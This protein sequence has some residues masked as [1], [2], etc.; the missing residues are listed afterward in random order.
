M[1][2]EFPEQVK[3][4]EDYIGSFS[5]K[6]RNRARKILKSLEHVSLRV[7]STEEVEKEERLYALYEEVYMHAKFKLL[8]LPSNYFTECKRIFKD[9]FIV[10]GFYK[11]NRLIAFGSGFF[12]PDNYLEAHYIGF[13][14]A[15]NRELELYQNILYS[16]IQTA[17]Q[18]GKQFLNLGRT[19]SEIKS[20]VGAKAYDLTCYI[21]PQNTLSKMVLK[22]F[23]Q[24]L[25]PTDWVPRNPF[26]EDEK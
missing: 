9:K 10:L 3:S 4:L 1:I 16:F 25:Q 22:P 15:L 18:H 11:D 20:T 19:A 21:R 14:Y 6:Y 24:F 17:I 2:V 26:K 8:K 23:I 12:A 5:K 13:D 7:L